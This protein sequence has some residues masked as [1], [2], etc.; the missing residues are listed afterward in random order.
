VLTVLGAQDHRIPGARGQQILKSAGREIVGVEV[1]VVD[2]H[3]AVLPTGEWGE[4]IARGANVM[5]GYWKM[6]DKTAETI[7]DGW[8]WT[9]D[10]G[11]FDDEGYLYIV[12][13]SKD[14]I[15]SGGENIYPRE[16]EEVLFA[17]PSI[18][19]AAVIGVPSDAGWGEEVKACVVLAPGTAISESELIDH[20]RGQLAHYKCP[21][22]VDFLTQIPRNLSGK[23]LKKD[24]RA[25][26]WRGRERG[27]N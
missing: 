2:E 9:G 24:L 13:R 11:Y 19:D 6:P 12:D 18:A 25:P 15:I 3:G 27:V 26:Y 20:C 14:M 5:K 22:S 1:R 17:H 7:R 10:I 21:R 4:V 23:V 16:I 8:L